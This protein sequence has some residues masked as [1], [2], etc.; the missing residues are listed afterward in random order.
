[1]EIDRVVRR[2][3]HT[4]E[5][6]GSRLKEEGADQAHQHGP[7]EHQTQQLPDP[8][9]ALRAVVVAH[10]GLSAGGDPDCN[11]QYNLEE[12]HNDHKGRQGNV[13][14]ILGDRA[15]P[16]QQ[17]IVDHRDDDDGDLGQHGPHGVVRTAVRPDDR[18]QGVLRHGQG[19]HGKDNHP[20]VV[21]HLKA[22]LCGSNQ[23]E[24]AVPPQESNGGHH[25]AGEKGAQHRTADAPVNVLRL[26]PPQG[27]AQGGGGPVSKEQAQSPAYDGDRENH[28]GG[29]VAQV[30]HPVAHKDLVHNVVE[31]GYDQRADTGERKPSQQCTRLFRGKII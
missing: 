18:R 11:V 2:A 9:A 21:G 28:A 4:D 16:D 6:A 22:G 20:I 14:A 10:N 30:A 27:H 12:L 17:D 3:K 24:Q 19:H 31:T 8:V 15:I 5:H 23:Q 7:L 29:R 13:R 25:D 26:P 1:M